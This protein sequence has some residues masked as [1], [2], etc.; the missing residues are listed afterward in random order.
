[1]YKYVCKVAASSTAKPSCSAKKATKINN[2]LLVCI[3]RHLLHF[4]DTSIT[5]IS[6]KQNF[7]ICILSVNNLIFFLYISFVLIF[8][9]S[10]MNCCVTFFTLYIL[11][12]FL[13]I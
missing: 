8:I 12:N 11:S 1:M 4:I 9:H 3:L 5:I 2:H 7:Y 10:L 6:L 13:Y